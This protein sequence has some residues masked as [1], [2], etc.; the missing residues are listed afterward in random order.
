MSLSH[1]FDDFVKK[2]EIKKCESSRLVVFQDGFSYFGSPELPYAFKMDHSISWRR[3]WQ[4][5]P[6]FFP[7]EFHGQR[8]PA[9]YTPR[10]RKESD[11]TE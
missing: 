6:V 7:G 8:S 2:F 9:G 1:C 10:G 3:E 11:M 4:S 5:T